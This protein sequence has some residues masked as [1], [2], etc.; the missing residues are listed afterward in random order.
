M[1]FL[2]THQL[3]RL[4]FLREHP[5]CPAVSRGPTV[6]H[7]PANPLPSPPS[8]AASSLSSSHI[9]SPNGEAALLQGTKTEELTV[10]S[11]AAVGEQLPAARPGLGLGEEAK[12]TQEPCKT[13]Q[14]RRTEAGTASGTDCPP[15]PHG[16]MP[17]IPRQ[18]AHGGQDQAGDGMGREA[19]TP[20]KER[21]VRGVPCHPSSSM[22]GDA[23]APTLPGGT[24]GRLFRA[25]T[26]QRLQ[27]ACVKCLLMC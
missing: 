6:S 22:R 5:D 2:V 18:G 25:N 15:S 23:E 12:C 27:T 9:F 4:R 24:W 21:G 20:R 14:G 13:C 11:P 3:Q 7:Q 19:K 10:A 8:R 1:L 26:S 16:R 17:F